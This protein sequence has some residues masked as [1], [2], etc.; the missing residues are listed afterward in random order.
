MFIFTRFRELPDDQM[1]H[2]DSYISKGKPIIGIRTATHAFEFQKNKNSP[3]AKYSWQ[4]KHKGWVEG[5]G[6]KILGETWVSHHGDHGKE[7]ARG[8]INGME[9]FQKHPVLN[10][11]KDIWC[12]SDVY[13]VRQLPVTAKVLVYGQVTSGMTPESPANLEKSVM[14]V[15]WTNTYTSPSGKKGR[16]LTST[17]GA[18]VDLVNEDLRRLLVNACFWAMGME[19]K[20]PKHANVDFVSE[21]KPTMFG[22]GIFE[23][24]N[25]PSK[26]ELR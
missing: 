14:P 18:S 26:Y 7:G 20:T 21:Y 19:S 22:F 1:K 23:K 25:Y 24:G 5:F 4:S 6:K 2:I 16:V 10:G 17:M 15:V 9:Q 13:T 12:P 11:V 8:L 3:Y